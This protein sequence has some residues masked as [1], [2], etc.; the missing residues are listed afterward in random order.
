MNAVIPAAMARRPTFS[1]GLTLVRK[2]VKDRYIDQSGKEIVLPQYD[3]LRPFSE[4]LAGAKK[5]E[6]WGFV[7]TQGRACIAPQYTSVG[8]FS[9]N[10]VA[11]QK[12]ANGF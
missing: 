5:G 3:F 9:E 7:D 10:R 11:F 4:G 2:H 6:K 8:Y 12:E 1:D